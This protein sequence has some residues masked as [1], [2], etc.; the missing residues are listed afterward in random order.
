[1]EDYSKLTNE[2]V[3]AK[4]HEYKADEGRAAKK[5]EV[6]KNIIKERFQYGRHQVGD[7]EL[8]YTEVTSTRF[9][10]DSFKLSEPE[11]YASFMKESV[12][13]RIVVKQ[14]E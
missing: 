1:M 14:C 2:E 4:Y 6:L 13:S 10:S 8:Q 3:L 5:V 11:K 12:S 9:D 7:Y